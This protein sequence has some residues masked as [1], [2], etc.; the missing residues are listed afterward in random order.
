MKQVFFTVF[1][2]ISLLAKT[3]CKVLDLI[4]DTANFEGVTIRYLQKDSSVQIEYKYK[5]FG[6]HLGDQ[7]SF[8]CDLSYQPGIPKPVWRNQNFLCFSSGCGTSCFANFLVPLNN[9][10]QAGYAGQ[11]LI[12]TANTIFMSLLHDT[13]SYEPYL[14]LKNY[15]TGEIQTEKFTHKDFPV[16]IP[17]EYLDYSEPH[18][19]GFIYDGR[20]LILYLK[21]NRK[22]Q[23]R[24]RI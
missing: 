2:F 23:V 19:N 12:D 5:E 15:T 11:F 17:I 16:A 6:K 9:K 7:Y 18:T 3:Q 24:V 21:E 8:S 1:I 20:S 10:H 4:A 13:V 22:L 14:K